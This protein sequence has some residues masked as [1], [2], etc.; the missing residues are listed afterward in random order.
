MYIIYIYTLYIYIYTYI[1]TYTCWKIYVPAVWGNLKTCHGRMPWLKRSETVNIWHDPN[2][3][4][5]YV[6]CICCPAARQDLKA[7]KALPAAL[8]WRFCTDGS[9]QNEQPQGLVIA[10][11]LSCSEIAC[12]FH[13]ISIC[14]I[15]FS[16]FRSGGLRLKIS[17]CEPKPQHLKSC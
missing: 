1:R 11:H 5:K 4:E 14:T 8:R 9:L 16:H 2:L 7:R 6:P 10:T 12:T 13:Y 15:F 3:Q 17:F